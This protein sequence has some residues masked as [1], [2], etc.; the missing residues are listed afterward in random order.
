[1]IR[2]PPRS[3]LFPYTTLFRSKDEVGLRFVSDDLEAT[4]FFQLGEGV[5]ADGWYTGL[6]IEEHGFGGVD[7]GRDFSSRVD[8]RADRKGGSGRNH[9]EEECDR[10][11][12]VGSR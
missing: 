2:R 8:L 6:V 7:F 9:E 10:G 1:M 5:F 3:T 4:P 11:A 12:H